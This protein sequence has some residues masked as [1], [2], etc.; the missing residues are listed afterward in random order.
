MEIKYR[1][2]FISIII[3]VCLTMI[4]TIFPIWQ[5]III[6]GVFAGIFNKSL[7]YGVL[8][9]AIG[10]TVSWGIYI[11]LNMITRNT[12]IFL[13][14]LGSLLFGEGFG[15]VFVLLI[16]LLAAFFGAIGAGIGNGLMNV[17]KL[18]LE[19]RHYRDLK[20]IIDKKLNKN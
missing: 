7:K 14:Q 4:L 20:I 13:D 16:I 6:P 17:I 1:S 10:V 8:G 9:G 15:W 12:Y 2:F 19:S 11:T 5:L 18:Y 3:V